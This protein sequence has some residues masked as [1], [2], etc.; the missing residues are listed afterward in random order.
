[1][2]E[3]PDYVPPTW[4]RGPLNRR[5]W[6][7]PTRVF[8]WLVVTPFGFLAVALLNLLVGSTVIGVLLAVGTVVAGIQAVIYAPRALRAVRANKRA[9]DP[10]RSAR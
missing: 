3:R 6:T 9:G 1:M 10:Q 8:A 7:D 5:F 4:T 2:S